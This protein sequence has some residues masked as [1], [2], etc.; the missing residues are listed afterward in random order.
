LNRRSVG[1]SIPWRTPTEIWNHGEEIAWIQFAMT[2]PTD[3]VTVDPNER[4]G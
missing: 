2:N 4:L 1:H 3:P